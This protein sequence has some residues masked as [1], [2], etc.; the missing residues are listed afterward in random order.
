MNWNIPDKWKEAARAAA[1]KCGKALRGAAAPL[2]RRLSA[3]L[4]PEHHLLA[5]TVGKLVILGA[6]VAAVGLLAAAR[7]ELSP[8]AMVR[9]FRDKQVLE[10]ATGDGFPFRTDSGRVLSVARVKG[11]TAVLTD[12]SCVMLDKKGREA[13]DH[14]HYMAD[15]VMKNAD[16][17]TL[18]YDPRAKAY[19]LCTLSGTLCRGNAAMPIIAGA[20]SPSGVFALVTRHDTANAHLDVYDKTGQPLHRW[21]SPTYYI[22]DVAVSPSGRLV[23]MCG[24][25]A[26]DDG[27]LR[28]AVII[29]KVGGSENLREYTFDGSLIFSVQFTDGDTVTA[30]GDDLAA[31]VS[32]GSEHCLTYRYSDRTLGGYDIAPDGDLALVLSPHADGQNAVVTVLDGKC[33][34]IASLETAMDAPRVAVAGD[35]IYL[36]GQ[37]RYACFTYAG[38][39]VKTGEIPADAQTVLPSGGSVLIQG[40]SSVTETE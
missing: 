11:G 29:Q 39:E 38:K 13:V 33:E 18:L 1:A 6:A 28:S 19:M 3:L 32:A 9:G 24:V 23:A 16:R 8:A 27:A 2:T 15:P 10:T 30:I 17:Y 40:I 26:A 31:R 21:K 20:V 4:R 14:T 7:V 5:V 36:I 37:S 12:A 34:E 35:R 22:S 25:T